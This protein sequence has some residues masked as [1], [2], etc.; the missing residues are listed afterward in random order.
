MSDLPE[1]LHISKT[2]DYKFALNIAS[3][4]D[5]KFGNTRVVSPYT[6]WQCNQ[7]GSRNPHLP[8]GEVL[9][10]A[11]DDDIE[12][13]KLIK[14]YLAEI[15]PS[16]YSYNVCIHDGPYYRIVNISLLNNTTGIPLNLVTF[17][18]PAEEDKDG[19]T[20]IMYKGDHEYPS[21]IVVY[22]L[23]YDD[24]QWVDTTNLKK[25]LYN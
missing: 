24:E 22:E 4:L 25:G 18:I 5:E 16:S 14:T 17:V 8:N 10:Y 9:P 2:D 13:E 12:T 3:K 21:F 7:D 19:F 23:Y 6:R 20:Y 11:I 15:L 1:T